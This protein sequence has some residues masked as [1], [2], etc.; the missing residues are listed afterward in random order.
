[1]YV[2]VSAN[3]QISVFSSWNLCHN[4]VN[5]VKGNKGYKK[6]KNETELINFI[7]EKTG[8]SEEVILSLYE[9]QKFIMDEAVDLSFKVYSKA[10]IND[11]DIAVEKDSYPDDALYLYID[12]SYNEKTLVYGYGLVAVKEGS[13]LSR[14]FSVG[15]DPEFAKQRNVAG[16]ILGAYAA[17]DYAKSLDANEV[18]ICYDYKGI[19]LWAIDDNFSGIR[20]Y[21]NEKPWKA[22][23]FYTNEY[24]ESMIEE[25][26][27]MKIHFMKI[28]AHSGDEFNEI[29]DVLAKKSV[30][31]L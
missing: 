11:K 8:F 2:V 7:N 15:N 18:V 23:N 22:N 3:N 16:E 9:N 14:S 30:G 29:A 31:L 26:K 17:M 13:E 24:K 20:N 19:E 12:G 25:Q 1:M 10:K 4:A 6:V 27:Y 28:K 5:G 21:I